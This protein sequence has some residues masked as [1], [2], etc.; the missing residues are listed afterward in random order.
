MQ[1]L[2]KLNDLNIKVDVDDFIS[3]T[4]MLKNFPEKNLLQW[5]RSKTT[6]DYINAFEKRYNPNYIHAEFS[7][8]REK[9]NQVSFTQ[10]KKL[11]LMSIR[12]VKGRYGDTKAH[13]D[14]AFE[15]AMWLNVDF[16]LWVVQEFQRMKKEEIQ[17]EANR[18]ALGLIRKETAY[19]YSQMCKTLEEM[20]LYQD[21]QTFF[22]HYCNEADLINRLVCGMSSKECKEKFGDTPRNIFT[23]KAVYFYE[24]EM[25]NNTL[26]KL[27]WN[28]EQRK[29]AMQRHLVLL[30]VI[31]EKKLLLKSGV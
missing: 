19:E 16:K 27:G 25:F 18:K 14:I 30:P 13:P 26:L 22:Y 9:S 6:L 1:K 31:A 2:I 8:L 24:L 28:F 23:D 15:F 5:L 29:E 11:N 7:E 17:T 20:R 12:S 10:L 4:D 3:L 21:K